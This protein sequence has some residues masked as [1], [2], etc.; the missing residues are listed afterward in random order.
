MRPAHRGLISAH[1]QSHRERHDGGRYDEPADDGAQAAH[2]P[3]IFVGILQQCMLGHGNTPPLL[4]IRTR[5]FEDC[6]INRCGA[7][8]Q[9]NALY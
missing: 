3:P 5:L 9:I 1:Y 8:T 4:H 6:D 2:G 7:L